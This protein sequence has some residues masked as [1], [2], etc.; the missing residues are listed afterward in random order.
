MNLYCECRIEV[1]CLVSLLAAAAD[2]HR[3]IHSS[4][5]QLLASVFSTF[6]IPQC[7]H[8]RT[9]EGPPP[10]SNSGDEALFPFEIPKTPHRAIIRRLPLARSSALRLS[11]TLPTRAGECSVRAP[12][13]KNTKYKLLLQAI[14]TCSA[15]VLYLHPSWRVHL[16]P[17]LPSSMRRS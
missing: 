1:V 7:D 8:E 15:Y 14:H 2:P 6:F 13:F 11:A 5:S 9:V 12:C 3:V 10:Y 4:R 16:P 17:L